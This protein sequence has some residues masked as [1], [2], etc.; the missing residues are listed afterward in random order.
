MATHVHVDSSFQC[1]VLDSHSAVRERI[2][3]LFRQVIKHRVLHLRTLY[4]LM[5]LLDLTLCAQ[6][7]MYCLIS[8][9]L[10]TPRHQRPSWSI[11]CYKRFLKTPWRTWRRR[12]AAPG[13]R[14]LQ[15]KSSSSI[16]AG[17][18]RHP[19]SDSTPSQT[20]V[21]PRRF[22][23]LTDVV[24][25]HVRSVIPRWSSGCRRAT[26]RTSGSATWCLCRRH[27][28]RA[29]SKTL[30]I[31]STELLKRVLNNQVHDLHSPSPHEVLNRVST[32]LRIL[33]PVS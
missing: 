21:R 18:L 26:T 17:T 1:P 16:P 33:A 4:E 28:S 10:H 8:I 22:P 23:K 6:R 19:D 31:Y 24:L 32:S 2:F 27:I 11:R 25:L 12:S 29:H 14:I 20:T 3:Q 7:T 30:T 9:S 5:S 13:V 15:Q